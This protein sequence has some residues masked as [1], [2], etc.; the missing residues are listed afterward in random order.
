MCALLLVLLPLVAQAST[1]PVVKPAR[2]GH[3]IFTATNGSILDFGSVRAG[4]TKQQTFS[5]AN[6]GDDTLFVQSL[7]LSTDTGFT[8]QFARLTIAPK[9]TGTVVVQFEPLRGQHYD[10]T[11][12]FAVANGV[13]PP[14]VTFHGL[15][16]MREDAEIS[17]TPILTSGG[18][19][20]V[21]RAH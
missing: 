16:T 5:F 19:N 15:G 3:A 9:Q 2:H 6:T 20:H 8:I 10:A 21:T 11:L 12:S 7:E 1:N 17:G 14:S 18:A 4:Q 13:V